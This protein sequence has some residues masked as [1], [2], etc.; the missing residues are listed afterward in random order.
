MHSGDSMTL[1]S[2]KSG[3]SG[4]FTLSNV[5]APQITSKAAQDYAFE[6]KEFLRK[7]LI[8]QQVKVYY[9]YDKSFTIKKNKWTDNEDDPKEVTEEITL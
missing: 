8:G 6:A 3:K 2:L 1:E 5:R 9:E 4:K 7:L